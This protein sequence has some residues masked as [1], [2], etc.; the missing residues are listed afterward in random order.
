MSWRCRFGW[1]SWGRWA[2]ATRAMVHFKTGI[3]YYE[4]TQVRV[5]RLCDWTDERAL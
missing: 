4:S 3:R 5:C 2:V 1:H